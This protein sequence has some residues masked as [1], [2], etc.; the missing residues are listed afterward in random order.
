MADSR[1]GKEGVKQSLCFCV[2]KEEKS[3][4]ELGD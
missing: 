2:D 1:G 4:G 3:S